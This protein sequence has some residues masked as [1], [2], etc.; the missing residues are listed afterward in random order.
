MYDIVKVVRYFVKEFDKTLAQPRDAS[1]KENLWE[2]EMPPEEQKRI[3]RARRQRLAADFFSVNNDKP[4]KFP[5]AFTFVY[6]SFMSLDGIGKRL[7]KQY[8]MMRLAAPYLNEL[9][10]LKDGNRFKS[11]LNQGLKEVGLRPVD[12]KNA[13]RQPRNV[14]YMTDI[15]KR[16]EEGDLKLRTRAL[17]VEKAQQRLELMVKV[18]GTALF[19][20]GALNTGL[21]L[22]ALPTTASFGSGILGAITSEAGRQTVSRIMFFISAFLAIRAIP[23]YRKLKKLDEVPAWW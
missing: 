6:R 15:L 19:G 3:K 13:W 5:A 7:D 10:D 11:I 22:A 17:E 1:S 21:L 23:S 12:F 8:D 4:F 2:N 20:F 14:A 9:V 16:L 18:M